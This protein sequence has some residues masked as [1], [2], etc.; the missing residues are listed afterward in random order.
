MSQMFQACPKLSTLKLRDN[1]EVSKVS[2]IS[3]MFRWCGS[4]ASP[5]YTE[6]IGASDTTKTKL[7]V[8][9]TYATTYIRAWN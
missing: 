4:D 1:F 5:Q 8:D 3:S 2:N 6:I 7:N 9:V